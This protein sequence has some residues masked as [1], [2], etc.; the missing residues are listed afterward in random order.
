VATSG[1]SIIPSVSSS[2]SSLLATNT[3]AISPC[4]SS[5]RASSPSCLHK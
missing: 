2:S 5:S 4:T 1:E 3:S